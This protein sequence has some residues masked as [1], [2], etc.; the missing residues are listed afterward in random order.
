MKST[1]I[2]KIAYVL[3][4]GFALTGA[5]VAAVP[6]PEATGQRPPGGYPDSDLMPHAPS[7]A[8]ADPAPPPKPGLRLIHSD[9]TGVTLELWTPDVAVE[10]RMAE[11]GP[12]AR[13]DV[14]GYATTDRAGWPQLP[15]RGAMLGIPPDVELHLTVLETETSPLPGAYDVCPV[16]QPIAEQDPP[17]RTARSGSAARASDQAASSQVVRY[18]GMAL[19]RDEEAYGS[20]TFY[21]SS[22]AQIVSTGYVR[23]QRVAQLRLHPFQY[24]PATGQLRH[25]R[26]LHIRIDFVGRAA[27]PRPLQRNMSESP[28]EETLRQTL[29]NYRSARVWRAQPAPTASHAASNDQD[30]PAYKVQVDR[31]GIYQITRGDLQAAGVDVANLDPRTLRLH[32]QGE[33]IGIHVVGQADGSFDAGDEMLFYGQEMDSRYTNVNVYWLTWGGE[34]GRRMATLDGTPSETAPT[35]DHFF[36]TQRVEEDRNYQSSRPSS[37]DNDRWYWNFLRNTSPTTANYTTTLS[38]LVTGPLSATVRGL[39]RGYDADPQ[40]HA[41]VYLN[42]HLID[43][44]TWPAQ[45]EYTFEETVPQSYLVEG[46]NVISV[47][48][49]ADGGTF[50][51]NW[52]EIGYHDTYAAEDDLLPFDGDEPGTWTFELSGFTSDAI[53]IFDVT[54]PGLPERI[55]GAAVEDVGGA[56]TVSFEHAIGEE[57]HYLALTPERRLSPLSIEAD[58]PSDLRSTTNGADYLIISHGDFI[59]DVAPLADCRAAQGLRTTVVDVQ[60]VYDEFSY[61]I[62][63]PTAIHDFLAYAYAHWTPPAPSYVLLVGDGHFD[64][65]DN[66]GRGEANYIPPYLADVDPWLGE[67]AADNRYVCVSGGDNLPDMHVGRLPVKTSAEASTVVSKILSYEQDPPPGDWNRHLLFVADNA[68]G[69]GDFAA[70]SDAIADHYVPSPFDVQKVHHRVTHGSVAETNAAIVEAINQGR[71]LVNYF[72]HASQQMWGFEHLFDLDDV[73]DLTNGYRLPWMVPMTCLDGYFTHPSPPGED[74]SCLGE[75]IVRAEGGGAIASWSPTGLGLSMGH[76]ILD[77]GLFKA[78]FYQDVTQLG[79]STT[80]AKLY[81]YAN[82]GGYRDLIDTYVLFGDPAL[83]LSLPR[84]DVGI[85][86][87]VEPERGVKPGDVITYTLSYTNA[88]PGIVHDIV[89]TDTLPSPLVNP[90]VLS[91]GAV[92]TPRV[93]SRFVWD[94]ADLLAGEGGTITITATIAPTFT[95][96]LTNAA[97]IATSASESTLDNNVA[98]VTT[99][100]EAHTVYLPMVTKGVE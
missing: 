44:A 13:V 1:T 4:L 99:V 32:N 28:F 96:L 64:F 80:Q 91:S 59:T 85:V 93:G 38:H 20:D 16:A 89:L 24:H 25:Y 70:S 95:G 54:S 62:F 84:P 69:G 81:L 42:G 76:D 9:E 12:C 26:H 15:V 63:D 52:F 39:F 35:P 10:P 27:T 43:E 49:A 23:S 50:F 29:L 57:H 46:T 22:I 73:A 90:S 60:D 61:G 77:E 47:A 6:A 58:S 83:A 33:E 8:S 41:R 30:A 31:D 2:P 97:S 66:Y 19:Q 48:C 55:V 3:I 75:S 74:R 11:N 72:G 87:A 82:S 92:I 36:T 65:K 68:D 40:Q 71:L 100:V 98:R 17:Y 67:V 34:D 88:G 56:Y 53:E 5:V 45:A 37:P 14:A 94:V 86:K 79:P 51:V 78:V 7:V 18:A 21:P